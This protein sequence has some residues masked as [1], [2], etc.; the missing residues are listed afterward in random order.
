MA[1]ERTYDWRQLKD[2]W[3]R[4][5]ALIRTWWDADLRRAG[6]DEVRDPR[7]NQVWFVDD[8]H[9]AREQKG[10]AADA[11]TL[12]YLPFPYVSAGGS[13]AA[14]P[15]MYCWD[16]PFINRALLL[17]GRPE[18]VRHHLLNHLFLIDR[19]G[20]VLTGN[21]TYYLTRSQTPLLAD[22]VV[23]Y[24]RHTGDRDMLLRSYPS[25]RHEYECYWTAPPHLTATGLST[26]VDAGDTRLRAELAAE[27]E[28]LDFTPI[29]DGDIR[30][31]VPLQ[32]NCA[33][34]RYEESLAWIAQQ[35]GR[36]DE[37]QMWLGRADKRK[38][39][40]RQYCWDRAVGFFFEYSM[41]RAGRLPFWSLAGFWAMWAG[42]AT[43]ED[44]LAM[45]PH[46][47]RFA[48]PFGLTETDCAYA[49]PHPE[50]T[51]LQWGYPSAWPPSQMIVVEAL[52]RYGLHAEA[53]EVAGAYVRCQLEEFDRTGKF[54]EKYNG[55]E[56]SSRL[57]RERT[58]CVPMHGWSTAS[59][60]W[61]GHRLF[62]AHGSP[63]AP[64]NMP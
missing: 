24:V 17:H 28:S 10:A 41:T 1:G 7:C 64:G 40:I 25:L 57:P 27:A 30:Q 26:N 12:L 49:S 18:I 20:F 33:L 47:R 31:C 22:A 44:A 52:D 59:V 3:Q 11:F 58:P 23:R 36:P 16:I 15:E 45:A 5:D 53:E 32:L 37:E 48:F 39:L 21:R 14:F 35:I 46:L 9:R 56:G 29:Y 61:L 42:V 19:Y 63:V 51:W 34:V 60:V 4:A 54:W 38:G 6:E 43:R 50:F 13:E 8:E 62:G 2:R 55:V